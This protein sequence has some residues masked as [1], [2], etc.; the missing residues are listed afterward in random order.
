V[1]LFD[2]ELDV[3]VAELRRRIGATVMRKYRH[4]LVNAFTAVEGAALL[5]ARET[6]SETDRSTLAA[7]LGAGLSRLR[8]PPVGWTG[9]G[10]RDLGGVDDVSGRGAEP[11]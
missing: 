4:D 3:E 1:P 9:G 5:M 10:P 6:L 2:L 8:E 11:A 7:V